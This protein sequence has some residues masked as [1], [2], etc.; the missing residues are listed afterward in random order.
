M[1]WLPEAS[2]GGTA[3]T[4][5]AEVY[6]S[7]AKN[8]NATGGLSFSRAGHLGV[9]LANGKVLVAG[10]FN[11]SFDLVNSSELYDPA[12]GTWQPTGGL[13][14]PRQSATA[15][16]LR[17]WESPGCGRLW[18]HLPFSSAELFDPATGS[19]TFTGLDA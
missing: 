8:W 6:D 10:G 3:F 13:N 19:W 5:K 4:E 14:I 11:G 2:T 12:A 15:T 1:C 18:Q 17:K 7:S 9:S 16:L